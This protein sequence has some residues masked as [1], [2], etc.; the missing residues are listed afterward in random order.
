[1]MRKIHGSVA[2]LVNDILI[3]RH[4][5]FWRRRDKQEYFDGCIRDQ[6]QCR[7]AYRYT[8]RQSVRHG[9]CGDYRGY[10]H[11]RVDVD[12]ERGIARALEVN[13]F[14]ANVPHKRYQRGS[15]GHGH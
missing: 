4:V 14:L 11:T 3:E 8:L 12:L 13:A 2:K 10:P 15:G 5:P 1:M 6:V 9:L 7:R